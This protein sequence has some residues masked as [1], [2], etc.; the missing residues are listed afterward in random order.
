MSKSLSPAA[1][2]KIIAYDSTDP[3]APSISEFCRTH[4]ISRPSFYNVRDRY[5][6]EGNAALNPRPRAPK[7][8]ARTFTND[9]A[10]IVL[11]VRQHLT[12]SGW[13]AGPKTIWFTVVD[14]AL[15][16]D[17]QIPSVSTIARILKDAGVVAKNPRKRPRTSYIRFQRAV[18]DGTVATRC[19]RVQTL[20]PRR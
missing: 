17:D 15:F 11:D 16:P 12:S 5:T 18:R 19:L 8:P 3:N 6:A 14:E 1:R 20:R 2:R 7:K 10:T 13:D 9:T 4:G